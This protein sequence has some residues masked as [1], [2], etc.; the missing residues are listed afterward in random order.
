MSF[1]VGTLR[2]GAIW[3]ATSSWPEPGGYITGHDYVDVKN[4]GVIQ[5]VNEFVESHP[6]RLVALSCDGFPSFVLKKDLP[7]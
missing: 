4:Y 6:V 5:A 7:S 3:P 2:T 1:F